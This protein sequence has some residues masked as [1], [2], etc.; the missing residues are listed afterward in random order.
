ME[1]AI[2]TWKGTPKEYN[3][4]LRG[5]TEYKKNLENLI[6]TMAPSDSRAL[7]Q[8]LLNVKDLHSKLNS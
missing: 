7:K 8:E 6:A 3:L 4:L 2:V 1:S 5:L